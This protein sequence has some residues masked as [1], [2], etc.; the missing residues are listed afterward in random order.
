MLKKA[1]ALLASDTEEGEV[2]RNVIRAAPGSN[3]IATCCS[4][5]FARGFA[6][7]SYSGWRLRR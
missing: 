2:R 4:S 1:L 3:S 7:R 6:Y 5:T